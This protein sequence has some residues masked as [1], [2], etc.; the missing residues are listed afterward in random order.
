[1]PSPTPSPLS[2]P[3]GIGFQETE[4]N[5]IVH[6]LVWLFDF[7]EPDNNEFLA[8][9]QF[10]VI[11]DNPASSAGGH[12]RR[13]DIVIF[14]NGLPLA[15]IELKNPA[16]ENATIWTAYNQF[17]TYKAQIPTLFNYNEILV[18]SDGIEARAGTITSGR[19]WFM[20][21]KTIEG[22]KIA[23]SAM[24]QLEVLLKG[25]FDK[26]K[27]LD[28]IRHFVVYEN[29]KGNILKKI[30]AYHQ[31]YA[32]NAAMKATFRAMGLP[33][34]S[35]R[36]PLPK[37]EGQYRGGL[38]F[39]G[40]V[41]IA[42]DLR[43]KQTLAEDVFWELVRDRQL[44]GLKFRRQ[45]Q[46]GSYVVDFYCAE[47]NLII[48]LDGSVH[49]ET[50]QA[51]KDVK[52]AKCLTTLGNT[53][54][55]FKNDEVLTNTED[56]LCKISSA[57]FAEPNT[58]SPSG[59]GKGEGYADK[60]IGVIW[61]T[62]GA[63]KSLSMVFYTGKLVLAMDNPTIVMLT[64]RNDL[65]GQLFDTF[66]RCQTLLRQSPVQAE[67]RKQLRELLKV[68][69]GG[70]VFTTIQKFMPEAAPSSQPSPNGRGSEGEGVMPLLSDRR[71]IIVIA[72]EAHR[73]QYDF[74]DGFARH[75]RDALPNASFIG[76]TGTPI[77]KT[78][79]NTMAVFGDYVD[80]YDI[81]QAVTDG[82]TVRIY[83]ESRLAKLELKPE[84]RP[85]IDPE[86]EE[87]TEGEEVSRKEKLKSRWARLEAIVGSEKRVKLIAQDIV[88]HFEKRLEA[89]EGKGMIVCMSRRI[90]VDLHKEIVRLRPQWYDK[91]DGKGIIK[92][93]M[94]GSADDPVEWQEHIRNKQRREILR[95]R[96]KDPNDPMNLAIVRDMWLTGFDAP[97]L[98]TMYVDKP[99][100]GHG[101]MQAI[102]RVNRVF[103]DKPGGL[104]VDYLGIADD[105]K[106]ALSEYTASGGKGDGAF[107]QTD[108]IAIML[109]KYEI[110]RAMFRGFD[111][112]PF[113][114]ASARAKMGLIPATMEHILKQDKGKERCLEN[115]T[116]LSQAFALSVPS[117]EAMNIR[118]EVGFFQ[119]VRAGL[120]KTTITTG[121]PQEDI[122]L[123]IKQIVSKA[124]A[125]DEVI[126]VFSAVGLKKPDI[127]ILSD[128]FLSE[129][130]KMP[131]KNLA[132]ELLKKLLS[133][134][135][136]IRRRK[137]LIQGKSFADMLEKSILK[138]QNKTIETAQVIAELIEL[139][140][141]MREA[142]KRGEELKLTEDELAFYD[143]LEVND[144]AVKVLGDETLRTIAREL[145]DTVHKNVTIDWTLRE[146]VQ[147]KLR[148]MVK[149][150]LRK[151]GYPPDKEKKAT[152]TV[153]EQATLIA[154]DWVA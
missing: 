120:A 16:D 5:R 17:E 40:L 96:M 44:Q 81:E 136:K 110:V 85:K 56:V 116:R 62:Q 153:L 31:Y 37:G 108:A 86:F 128:E 75:I 100:R 83:Y 121:K 79:R 95:D 77:E 63:G 132:F 1:M 73:S 102:A 137:N 111:Y 58:P 47:K 72:D 118:D 131:H 117:A 145:V 140:K 148:I 2:S 4:E 105:L 103:K 46:I 9:N 152:E 84:E 115:V 106:R 68:A 123:A 144:S 3:T 107:N 139:A 34:P 89:M 33:Q 41:D 21:W 91:D 69:S 35:P 57:A 124:V 70:I 133:D 93:V 7:L 99:M 52:R 146:N 25:V 15:V 59:R 122:E 32:V 149:K 48:E 23:S 71:N 129:V 141:D 112:Q 51:A 49:S 80:I 65:D 92:V 18:I 45:H 74:I 24:A 11:E 125:S 135:I 38:E 14:V 60:R 50:K 66:C 150:V 88:N 147:A 127:S 19:E 134:E 114:T 6:D 10:T 126:D 12:N 30:A 22:E 26:R 42:R 20:P 61:H 36:T 101:L 76:F 143:A 130:K 104:V 55:R 87:V 90:C 82:A 119:A 54:I 64:D 138:Y 154:K 13:P 27:L 39:S 43:K 78:D 53:V 97:S 113:F 98:H 142:I 29:D 109:E 94:T 8:V 67:D 151:H 28:I